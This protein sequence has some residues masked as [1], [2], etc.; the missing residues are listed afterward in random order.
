M[1]LFTQGRLKKKGEL[2]KKKKPEPNVGLLKLWLKLKWQWLEI[3]LSCCSFLGI[4]WYNTRVLVII[5]GKL[6]INTPTKI[7]TEC[8]SCLAF[9]LFT[10]RKVKAAWFEFVFIFAEEFYVADCA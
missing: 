5:I 4:K 6:N 3:P 7:K 1:L 2:K 9:G 8:E 10:V